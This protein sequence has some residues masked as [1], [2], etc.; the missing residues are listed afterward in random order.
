MNYN[1]ASNTNANIGSRHVAT[2]KHSYYFQAQDSAHPLVEIS[3]MGADEYIQIGRWKA[4]YADI[5]NDYPMKRADNLFDKLISD[6]NLKAAIDEVNRSH[7][8]LNGH[9]PNQMTLWV[10]K[11]KWDRVKELRKIITDG[12]VQSPPHIKE[13]YDAN[14]R[15]WRT[16]SEPLLWPDQ[17]VH[18]ALI[19]TI[20]PVMMR[21]M[22]RYCCGSIRGRG[23]HYAKRAIEKWMNCDTKGTRYCF[24]CD[25]RHFYDSLKPEIVMDRMRSL[26]KDARVLDLISRIVKDGI[27]IGAYPSQ[28]FANT[29][30]QPLDV[31]IRQS[32][33]CSHYVRYMDNITIFGSNKRNLRK[34]KAIVEKW[35]NDH[36]LRLK[37]D[38][39]IFPVV[40]DYQPK[41]RMPDAVGYRYGR[42]YT[43]PR[44]HNLLRIKRGIRRY[45]KRTT[46]GRR[47]PPRM[48]NSILSRLGQLKHCNNMNI[49]RMIFKG[50]K[51]IRALKNIVREQRKELS[52]WNMFLEAGNAMA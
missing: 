6:K 23:T 32:G 44:K 38:W 12:F 19:Q 7:R 9:K 45:R 40:S 1:S 28:W 18:H 29:T 51:I 37:G 47:I 49:Y 25:I 13:R 50:E 41:G 17:Y 46:S 30:L 14:A 35:L 22:D 31:I 48:A 21:G 52:T 5:R 10:E 8:W 20:Q 26:I 16:I 15:K 11:T 3:N 27:K 4:R 43:L 42:G 36:E 24:S 33:L 34:L 39:Q 2:A